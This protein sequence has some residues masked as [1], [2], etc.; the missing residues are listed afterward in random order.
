[1]VDFG[2]FGPRTMPGSQQTLSLEA[3]EARYV[4]DVTT[5]RPASNLRVPSMRDVD[6]R[7]V[8][9][10]FGVVA[11]ALYFVVDVIASVL[12]D[13]YSYTGQT[14]S[15]LSAIG[16]PTRW[17]WVPFGIVFAALMTAFGWGVWASAGAKRAL[18]IVGA[19]LITLGFLGLVAWPFAPMHQR[20]VLAAGGGTFSDTLHLILSGADGVLFFIA[21][22]AGAK[23]FGRRFRMYSILTIVV[24]LVFGF[25]M[26]LE[27]PKVQDNESTPWIGVTERIM[28]YSAW[29]WYAVLGVALLRRERAET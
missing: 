18:R 1:M 24:V 19:S 7:G 23:A 13:G 22:V 6:W 15:E 26:S 3:V 16:A 10:T 17:L 12:Y 8:S 27:S 29:L 2:S 21:A 20:D 9:L 28:L 5:D 14:I 11:T 4:M 25:L